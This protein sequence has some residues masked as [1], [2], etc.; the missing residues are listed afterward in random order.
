HLPSFRLNILR[1]PVGTAVLKLVVKYTKKGTNET[2]YEGLE[3][4]FSTNNIQATELVDKTP[5][6]NLVNAAPGKRQT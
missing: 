4:R 5:L 3:S 1:R 6:Q 2:Y